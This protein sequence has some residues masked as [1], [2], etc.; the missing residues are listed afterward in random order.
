[1]F[2]KEQ[3]ESLKKMNEATK[4]DPLKKVATKK[5]PRKLTEAQKKLMEAYMDAK[6]EF[7]EPFIVE[8]MNGDIVVAIQV[9]GGKT[10]YFTVEAA[11][12]YID[13]LNII[14]EKIESGKAEPMIPGD[15]DV[16]NALGEGILTKEE[17]EMMNFLK[18][19]EL[20]GIK[21]TVNF[22]NGG[23]VIQFL[24]DLS[25]ED[26]KNL[27]AVFGNNYNEVSKYVKIYFNKK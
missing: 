21:T 3:I 18:E 9:S 8:N 19:A 11:K 26:V 15:P 27:K 24:D 4:I 16:A 6:I 23:M 7:S 12:K 5:E 14:I 1:M 25:E 10:Y 22:G 20:K 17:F 2:T 13:S